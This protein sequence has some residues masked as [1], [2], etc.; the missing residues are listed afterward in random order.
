M[1]RPISTTH[2]VA[3]EVI[4]TQ[5]TAHPTTTRKQMVDIIMQE[6]QISASG[7]SYYVDRACRPLFKSLQQTQLTEQQ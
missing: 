1:A 6:M 5:M 3:V 2:N 7:A 4:T